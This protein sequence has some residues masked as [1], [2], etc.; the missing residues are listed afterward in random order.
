MRLQPIAVLLIASI[1]GAQ[2]PAPL[3]QTAQTPSAPV[4]DAPSG[5]ITVPAGTKIPL[6]LVSL[7]KSISTKPGDTVRA[8]VAFPVTV[9]T[10]IAIPS[11]T[12]VEGTVETVTVRGPHTHQPNVQIHF[13]KLLFANGYV[14]S[15]DAAKL[16]AML[17][18]P[19]MNS[20]ST[21]ELADAG[22]GAPLLGAGKN[23]ATQPPT[24]PPLSNPGPNPVAIVVPVVGTFAAI[25]TLML[26]HA[27]HSGKNTDFILYD[28]GWQ[29]QMVLQSPL[30]LDA[31]KV[32][33]AMATPAAN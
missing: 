16:D 15:I 32:A 9:G 11:D 13:T 27:R 7:I 3:A 6:I 10:Q 29:F 17:I 28:N 14:A 12:Y 8:E 4:S 24:L 33:A 5:T 21:Y 25:F 26:L 30:T 18:V 2:T 19:D 22:A 1:C 23:A 31:A 20:Q